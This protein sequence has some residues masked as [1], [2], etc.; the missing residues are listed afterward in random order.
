MAEYELKRAL[1]LEPDNKL[2]LMSYA[3]LLK[4]VKKYSDSLDI[5]KN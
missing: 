1:S 5:L 2:I 3:R 4:M